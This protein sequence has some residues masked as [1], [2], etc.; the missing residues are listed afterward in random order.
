MIRDRQP[1][2]LRG[3]EIYDQLE[4][5]GLLDGQVGWLGTFEDLDVI[6]M[7]ASCPA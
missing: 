1:E 5:R 6:S 7:L 3:P 4:L 2:R